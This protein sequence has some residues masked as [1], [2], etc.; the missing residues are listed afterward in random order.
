MTVNNIW[1]LVHKTQGKKK[2]N[3]ACDFNSTE[4]CSCNP[5]DILDLVLLENFG[6]EHLPAGI[7]AIKWHHCSM[8]E[9]SGFPFFIR[10]TGT[11][12]PFEM[13]FLRGFFFSSRKDT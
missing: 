5:Q 11:G 10:G 4:W 7:R 6:C 3:K 8:N 9:M 12:A 1:G 2:T 13:L